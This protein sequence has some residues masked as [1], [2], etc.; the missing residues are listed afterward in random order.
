MRCDIEVHDKVVGVSR[1]KAICLVAER[2]LADYRYPTRIA[3]PGRPMRE[4]CGRPA[5]RLR[6][7]LGLFVPSRFD[8]DTVTSEDL[9]KDIHL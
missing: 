1:L 9:V 4:G 6:Y 5:F 2:V 7:S 8:N 3:V